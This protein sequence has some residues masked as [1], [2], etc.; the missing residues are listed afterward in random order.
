M[1]NLLKL[2][3]WKLQKPELLLKLQEEVFN[4][5]PEKLKTELFTKNL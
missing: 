1:L 2:S 3:A 5:K 4:K